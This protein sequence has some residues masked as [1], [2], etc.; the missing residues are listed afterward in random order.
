MD[1][2]PIKWYRKNWTPGLSGISIKKNGRVLDVVFSIARNNG[3]A[4]LLANGGA[5]NSAPHTLAE[6]LR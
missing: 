6:I 3:L 2:K 1:V 5:G 4:R